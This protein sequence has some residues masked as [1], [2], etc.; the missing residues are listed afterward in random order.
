[1]RPSPSITFGRSSLF[2]HVA[3]VQTRE[4]EVIEQLAMDGFS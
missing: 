4:I 1:M 2:C 3:L